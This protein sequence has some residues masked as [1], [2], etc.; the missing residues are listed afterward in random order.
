VSL[1]GAGLIAADD[2]LGAQR[3][4]HVEAAADL[5]T[6]ELRR[7]DA[8]DPEGLAVEKLTELLFDQKSLENLANEATELKRL[9][10][11]IQANIVNDEVRRNGLGAIDPARMQRAIDQVVQSFELAGKP[12][13]AQV[14]NAEYLPPLAQRKL[15]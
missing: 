2:R 1:A 13:V 7:R 14:F 11:A 10:L 12:T 3:D 15:D 4:R 9:Q 5:D 6:E 8:G